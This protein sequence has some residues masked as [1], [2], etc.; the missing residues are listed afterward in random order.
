[1]GSLPFALQLYSVRDH[2]EKDAAA[3]L[4]QVKEAGYDFVETAGT[5][6]KTAAEFRQILDDCGLAAVS[7]H[8]G[9]DAITEK[10]GQVI[11][12]CKALGASFA[13]MPY[14][15]ADSAEGWAVFGKALGAGGE[16]LHEA[17]IPLC[18]HNHT[19]EFTK[20]YDGKY[21]INCLLDAAD[22][23][24][25]G[26]QLD[27]YWAQFGGADASA[28]IMKYGVRCPI[29][30]I[31]DGKLGGEQPVLTEVGNGDMDWSPI[32]QA[33]QQTGVKW[34]IVEQDESDKDSLESAAIS[35]KFMLAR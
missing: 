28:L 18:Y 7:C 29:I 13:V 8:V 30:H 26:L 17:G 33:A 34:Y 21:A 25:L 14:A 16:K 32:F 6:G 20:Q 2:M 23:A 27:T 5:A 15:D 12:D 9:Y 31:K 4:K 24:H 22:P 10:P 35:A 3:T 11:E 1:M 19:H